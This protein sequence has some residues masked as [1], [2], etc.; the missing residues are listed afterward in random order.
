LTRA[1]GSPYRVLHHTV[2]HCSRKTSHAMT[3][4]VATPRADLNLAPAIPR[5]M[6][7]GLRAPVAASSLNNAHARPV[8][9]EA[10]IR[11]V[12]LPHPHATRAGTA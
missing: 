12:D 4:A 1:T 9:A 11:P 10:T 6:A 7:A 5:T 3:T 2:L 8:A